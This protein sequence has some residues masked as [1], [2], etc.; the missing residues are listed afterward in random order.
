MARTLPTAALLALALA[1]CSDEPSAE[2][3][4]RQLADDLVAETGGALGREE[5]E[6]VAEG[7]QEAFGDESY[8]E[9]LAAA[10]RAGEE[11]EDPVRDTVIDL[12][13]SCGALES[14]ATTDG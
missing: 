1:A 3:E 4:R 7:L 14:V 13:A 10:E 9:L 11:G 6:C 12:F 2:E 8:E 5:A